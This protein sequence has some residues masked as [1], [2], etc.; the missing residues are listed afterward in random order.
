L[1][2]TISRF[3]L[4]L[5][6]CALFFRLGQPALWQDE[7]ETALLGKSVLRHGLPR[8]VLGENLITGQPSLQKHES[9][10]AGVWIWNTWLPYYLS[11]ASF[12]VFGETTWAARLP[13]ALSGLLAFL[14]AFRLFQHWAKGDEQT[15]AL[16]CLLLTCNVPWLLFLRQCRYY[17]LIAAGTL[18]A[19]LSYRLMLKKNPW[20]PAALAASLLFLSHSFFIF[21]LLLLLVLGAE[22][23]WRRGEYEFKK[24]FAAVAGLVILLNLP[25]ALYFRFWSRPGNHLYPLAESWAFLITFLLWLQ[26]F[27]ISVP[28]FL[29]YLFWEKPWRFRSPPPEGELAPGRITL[30][31]LAAFLGF[32]SLAGAEPYGRY[33]MALIPFLCYAMGVWISKLSGGN[34]YLAALL[35]LCCVFSNLFYVL[36]VKILGMIYAPQPAQS[37]SGMMRARLRDVPIGSPL[38]SFASELLRGPKGYVEEVFAALS[39][40]MRPQESAFADADNLSYLFYAPLRFIGPKEL[41]SQI[42]DWILPSPWLQ[43]NPRAQERIA[44]LL[45]RYPYEVIDVSAPNILWQNKSGNFNRF[46]Q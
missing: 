5:A 20:G 31:L 8:V 15:A 41:E 40:R 10:K 22:A 35:A 30:I 29:L 4:V 17:G 25:A 16:A 36:P 21:G 27:I 7:A 11:A 38:L 46:I 32:F 23:L 44:L 34:G 13:F 3:F 37:V 2:K 19:V 12:A 45:R 18:A 43:F 9:N 24:K 42:P 39:S 33:L 14:L 6:A 26:Q 28:L 1:G